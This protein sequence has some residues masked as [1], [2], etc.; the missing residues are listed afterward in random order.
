MSDKN[1]DE[2]RQ[3]IEGEINKYIPHIGSR[4]EK[5]D[6]YLKAKVML[7]IEALERLNEYDDIDDYGLAIR[8]LYRAERSGVE[9]L[10]DIL[11]ELGVKHRYP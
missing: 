10:H 3:F 4:N 2:I 7:L 8:D 9:S 6:K 5:V 11:D 1:F